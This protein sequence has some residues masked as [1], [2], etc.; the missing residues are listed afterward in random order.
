MNITDFDISFPKTGTVN[1]EPRFMLRSKIR[2]MYSL[3]ATGT[4]LFVL[5]TSS[6]VP[7]LCINNQRRS[8]APKNKNKRWK[9]K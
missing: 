9:T 3:Q 6:V 5:F 2:R 7:S 4:V 8:H 1:Y